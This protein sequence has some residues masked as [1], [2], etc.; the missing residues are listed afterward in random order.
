M[1]RCLVTF[2]TLFVLWMLVA[3]ANHSL[4]PWHVYLFVGG[5]F[6]TYPALVL[7]ARAGLIATLLAGL[8]FD[9]ATP[10]P[11]GL[12]TVLFAAAHLLIFNIRDRVPREETVTR[13][14]IALL[15]NLA[16]FLV[17]SFLEIARIRVPGAV[18]PRLVF[19]LLC[20]QVFLVLIGPWFFALQA[21]A[22]AWARPGGAA[23]DHDYE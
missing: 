6:V 16:I 22:N 5:L 23:F 20:S 19:D 7:P 3:Q 14:V 15:A 12:H 1:R 18:W 9:S 4:A 21:A 8:V 10:V 2:L 17:F 13:V 11:F